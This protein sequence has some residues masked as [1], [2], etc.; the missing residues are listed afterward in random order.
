MIAAAFAA[1]VVV[2]FLTLLAFSGSDLDI[3][4][5]PEDNFG[6]YDSLREFETILLAVILPALVIIALATAATW[7]GIKIVKNP[8]TRA[9]TIAAVAI[10]GFLSLIYFGIGGFV[11][12][13]AYE[14]S[15]SM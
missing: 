7:L 13:L 10:A 2:Y 12:R 15:C 14:V 1:T 5:T 9:Q 3:P 4:Q 11:L 8:S 6:C